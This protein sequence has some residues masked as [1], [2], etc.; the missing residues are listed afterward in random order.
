ME[1]KKILAGLILAL[2]L[3]VWPVEVS[4]A[5]PMGTA[6]TY[7]GRL[8][9]ANEA[10]DGL[11][12]FEFKLYDSVIDGNQVN[13]TVSFR[14][15]EVIDGYFTVELDF[16][17]SEFYGD[18]R[19]LEIA[20]RVSASA[21]PLTTLSPRQELTPSPYALYAKS[22]GMDSDWMVSDSN[23]YSIPPGNVGI[24]TTNPGDKFYVRGETMRLY[25]PEHFYGA[26]TKL[27]FG[28][29]TYVW[30]GEPADDKMELYALGGISLTGGNVGIGTTDPGWKLDVEGEFGISALARSGGA[31][32]FT[33]GQGNM[34][35]C[36]YVQSWAAVGDLIECRSGSLFPDAE[37]R[38]TGNGNVQ[39][40]GSYTSPCADFAELVETDGEFE[41]GDVLVIGSIYSTKPA[42][43]G[44]SSID[45]EDNAG[46]IPMAVMG[47]VPCKVSVENGRIRAGDLLVTS[48]K[49]G[50][51]MRSIDPRAGTIVAKALEST[52]ADG[53]INVLVT[54]Q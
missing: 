2:S 10:A 51:A 17:S 42:F 27:H 5:S 9:D 16:G 34:S 43:I 29:G 3:A 26:G 20:V 14:E 30:I 49:P 46:K 12:E 45:T 44:G 40:D 6:F 24:G 36:L 48:S 38:V 18:A 7:Q 39:A 8:I 19:W 33:T 15:V 35:D 32:R 13:W 28:D 52:D 21:D 53:L 54:L 22:S 4:E 1:T 50:Y 41:P 47:I 25:H 37:F 31:G 23:M 11:Y